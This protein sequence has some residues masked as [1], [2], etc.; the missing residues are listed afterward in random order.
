VSSHAASADPRAFAGRLT[1]PRVAAEPLATVAFGVVL[2]AIAL[3][4]GGGLQLGPLT[5]VELAVDAAAGGLAAAAI[6]VGGHTRRLWGAVTLTLMAALV[7]VTA[8]SIMWAV[9]PSGAWVEADRTLSYLATM[10]AGVALVRLFPH[11]WA[12]LLGGVVLASVIV[13]GYA[14]LTKVFPGALNAD[15]VYARLREPFG[16]WNAVGLM[17]AAAGPACLWLGARR[18]GHAAISALAYPALGLLVVALLLAYSR[19]ALLALA[20]GCALWFAIVPL[21]LRGVVVL[22]SSAFCGGLVAFWAFAENPLS[23]DN[24]PLAERVSA[25]HQLGIALAAMLL[26]LLAAGLAIGFASAQRAPSLDARRQAGVLVLLVLALVP[27]A[28][29]GA[30]SLSS[31]G[32]GGS[33]SNGWTNLTDPHA[34]GNITNSPDRLTAVGSVRAR[35]WNEALKI[36]KAHKALGVGAGS[37]ATVR[38]RYRA[39]TLDVRHAHG[40]VVQT[41][42]DLGL[43]GATVSLA[44]LAAWLAAATRTV[45]LWGAGRRAPWTPERVGMATLLAICVVF[46]VHSF[47]DWTWFVPGNAILALLCAG[48]LIGRGPTDEPIVRRTPPRLAVREPWRIALAAAAVALALVAAWTSWQPQRAVAEGS[49]ALGTAEAG[50]FGRARDQIAQA[51]RINPLSVDLLF[52]QAAIES[53]DGNAGGARSAL[54]E[55]VRKEP[56]NPATWLTLAEFELNEGRKPQALSAVGSA[57]YLDPRSQ[58]AITTYL[59]ASGQQ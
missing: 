9:E 11:R 22:A 30:L 55:A 43:V 52:Q 31:R 7:A 50:N 33:L 1:L 20:C 16:Y 25:G 23:T 51:Q 47:V 40:Y 35:Y 2:A 32:L 10:A 53:A 14:L 59:Q 56:A 5:K 45:G 39:D 21:R 36:A 28:L 48:W 49:D 18:S 42:A 3:Q 27:V 15:E 46:G 24:V 44:L 13:C 38:P 34:N 19:G 26:V 29:V 17:A 4:G 8:L 12:A 6:V 37:Y 54:Q 58:E 41:L 57:L